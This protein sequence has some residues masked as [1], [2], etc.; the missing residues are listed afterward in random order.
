[1]RIQIEGILTI[2]FLV[3][4]MC[5]VKSNRQNHKLT[6]VIRR[7][8]LLSTSVVLF[9]MA[10]LYVEDI[11]PCRVAYSFLMISSDWMLYNLFFFSLEWID[12]KL[13]KWVCKPLLRILVI[14]DSVSLFCNIFFRHMFDLEPVTLYDNEIYFRLITTPFYSLHFGLIALL[15]VAS[16]ILLFYKAITAPLF[17]R[18]KYLLMGI[19]MLSLIIFN[20]LYFKSAVDFSNV[21]CGLEGICIYYCVFMHTPQ[22]LMSKSLLLVSKT[23]S[24]GIFVLDK[25]GKYIYCNDMAKDFLSKEDPF[26][27]ESGVTLEQWCLNRCMCDTEEFTTEQK[28]YRQKEE[29]HFSIQLQRMSDGHNQL[30]G[31]YFLIQDFTDEV[32]KLKQEHFLATHDSLTG[33]Y[34]KEYFFEKA[35]EFID[36]HED[37]EL[38]MIYTDIKNFELINDFFGTETGDQ[39]LKNVASLLD[40]NL[41]SKAVYG[42]LGNDNFAILVP[43]SNYELNIQNFTNQEQ[44][45]KNVDEQIDI[46]A[47]NYLGI[48]HITE[49]NIPISVMCDRAK[50]AIV[51]IKDNQNQWIAYYDEAFRNNLLHEQELI[52]N[53][54][55]A[56][57]YKHLKMYLQPQVSATGKM[58]G[59]EALVRWEHPEKGRIMPGDFI[60]LFE[61]NGL[62]SEVDKYIWEEACIKLK[63]WQEQGRRDVYIS[64]NISPKDFYLMDIYSILTEL[65][66]RYGIEKGSLKLEITETAMMID[67]E[68]QLELVKRLQSAGF[69]VEMDDFGSG[70]SSLNM[71]KD[72]PVD[73]LKIDMGFLQETQETERSRSILQLIISLAKQLRMGLVTEGVET[74]EQVAYLSDMGC[75]VFQGYYFAKPMDVA[76]FE[77]MYM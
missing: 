73:V 17:Y 8:L 52:K 40:K 76:S 6:Q 44:F 58:L 36:T 51:S 41:R 72:I 32:K 45:F 26:C 34:N 70:Y 12:S 7:I 61:K 55:D 27:D 1:M 13:Q 53:L 28:F 49:R 5:I 42:R 57:K 43:K 47:M 4:L 18:S 71:L 54:G 29:Y 60:P 20:G 48:Y 67:F 38:N 50:M 69:E 10:N 35:R 24:V 74:A 30:Q 3:L 14:L 9:N 39:V 63:E 77:E 19:V 16:L 64:V 66:T 33:I 21:L 2:T 37:L 23:M 46:P 15:A 68:R 22:R 75:E 65:V 56:I 59:A 25:D 31:S 62:I 11:V